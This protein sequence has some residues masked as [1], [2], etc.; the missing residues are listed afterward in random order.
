LI[1]LPSKQ[2]KVTLEILHSIA[3]R[4]IFAKQ[5]VKHEEHAMLEE[6]ISAW[7][8]YE[9]KSK[10]DKWEIERIIY[11]LIADENGYFNRTRE[12]MERENIH[13]MKM[14]KSGL[15]YLRHRTSWAKS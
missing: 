9:F 8:E 3:L 12:I 11:A 13:W 7:S 5:S 1:N 6:G 4:V 2:P 15:P 10:L 14:F